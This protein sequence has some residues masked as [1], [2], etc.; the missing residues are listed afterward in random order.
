MDKSEV[1]RNT[2]KNIINMVLQDALDILDAD[3]GKSFEEK[4]AAVIELLTQKDNTEV[5]QLLVE[6]AIED[7]EGSEIKSAFWKFGFIVPASEA[8]G[9]KRP[10]E[11]SLTPKHE[12]SSAIYGRKR[13][14]P[15]PSLA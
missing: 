14:I 6:R 9:T 1:S 12:S 15:G 11:F 5:S 3:D 10:G 2:K 13:T 8:G 7:K 4:R